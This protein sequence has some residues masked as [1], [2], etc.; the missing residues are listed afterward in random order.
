MAMAVTQHKRGDSDS[1]AY[2]DDSND[3][4]DT[5]VEALARMSSREPHKLR[6]RDRTHQPAPPSPPSNNASRQSQASVD[7]CAS[8]LRSDE[9]LPDNVPGYEVPEQEDQADISDAIPASSRDFAELFPS[10]R[11]LHIHHDDATMD[12]NMNLRVDTPVR[13]LSGREGKITLFHLRMYDLKSRDFSLRRYCRDSG[14]E[15]CHSARKSQKH[16]IGK[17]P[18]LQRSLSNAYAA[19]KS[20]GD[21]KSHHQPTRLVRTDSGYDSMNSDT[22]E[23]EEPRPASSHSTKVS[24]VASSDTVSIEFS[25]YAHVDIAR[26]GYKTDK[27]YDF[28]YWGSSYAWRKTTQKI[29]QLR[30]VSYRLA[31]REDEQVVARIVPDPLTNFAARDEVEKGGWI[32]P[33]TMWISDEKIID[34]R[35]TDIADVVVATGLVVLVD[36]SIRRRFHSQEAKQLI[37]PGPM[38]AALSMNRSS[39]PKKLIDDT[40]GR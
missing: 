7:T 23:A 25:N 2:T 18:G 12:G 6:D 19:L 5:P 17:R 36:D 9:A 39:A 26:K 22:E 16:S 13:T 38:F 37:I 28:H 24:K 1:S 32:P 29:G 33:C 21:I 30:E 4:Y 15:I 20:K 11:K 31:R 27:R 14:R 35:G 34:A 10:S 8:S 3:S 40:F